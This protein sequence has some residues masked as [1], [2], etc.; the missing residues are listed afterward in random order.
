MGVRGANIVTSILMLAGNWI[1]YAGTVPSVKNYGVIMFGQILIGMAQPFC[2]STPTKYSDSWFSNQGRT[3]ATALST[4]AN[5]FGAAVGQFVNSSV[6]SSPDQ[7]PLMVLIIAIIVSP[8]A[9]FF[10]PSET[11]AK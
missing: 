5:P 2:L 6:A 4:L 11:Q 10:R 3:S 7:V 8:P 9:L 1:R